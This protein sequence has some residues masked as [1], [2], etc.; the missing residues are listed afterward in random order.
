MWPSEDDGEKRGLRVWPSEDDGE[1]RG[2]R[3]IPVKQGRTLRPSVMAKHC[4]AS[5]PLNL[6]PF[7]KVS[8]S[9]YGSQSSSNCQGSGSH[10]T[11]HQAQ[12]SR[13]LARNSRADIHNPTDM[14]CVS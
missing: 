8:P 14:G 3:V 2:F 7:T 12:S 11:S 5:P 13:I 9:M 6:L 1:E 10:S 4:S